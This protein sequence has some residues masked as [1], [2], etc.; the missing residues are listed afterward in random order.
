[1]FLFLGIW[2]VASLISKKKFGDTYKRNTVATVILFVFMLY[3]SIA[4]NSFDIFNCIKIDGVYYMKRDLTIQCWEST[5]LYMVFAIGIPIL[6]IWILGFPILISI[7]LYRN[8]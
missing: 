1:M 5:H 2:K 3:P 6:I 7:I 4:K 8:K